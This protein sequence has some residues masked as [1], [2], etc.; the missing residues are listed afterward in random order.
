MSQSR[1]AQTTRRELIAEAGIQILAAQGGRALTHRAV[2][3]QA[4]LPLGST[5]Y[6]APTRNSLIDLIVRVLADRSAADLDRVA[7]VLSP[8]ALAAGKARPHLAAVTEALISGVSS[9][10]QRPDELRARYALLLELDVAA[11]ARAILAERS[12]VQQSVARRLE[13]SLTACGIQ[14]DSS[15]AREVMELCDAL[16]M[17][18][19]L[20][21]DRSGTARIIRTH[22]DGLATR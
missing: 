5:S 22:V 14:T 11:P 17:R 15:T 2:D 10:V 13:E 8:S 16:V 6:Y 18:A 9:L 1:P 20:T 21:G 7:A 3:R 12:P 19:I 4:N